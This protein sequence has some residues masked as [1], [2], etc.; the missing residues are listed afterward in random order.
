MASRL[1]G[2]MHADLK[3]AMLSEACDNCEHD[4]M[5]VENRAALALEEF[6]APGEQSRIIAL[7]TVGWDNYRNELLAQ[8][9]SP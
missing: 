7:L 5:P 9:K 8:R 1:L 2:E 4:G 3:S 6:E